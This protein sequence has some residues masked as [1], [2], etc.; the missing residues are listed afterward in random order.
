MLARVIGA[1]LAGNF[2]F[3]LKNIK[4]IIHHCKFVWGKI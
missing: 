2:L 3:V 1:N 4:D